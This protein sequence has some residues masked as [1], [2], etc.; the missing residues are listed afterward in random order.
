MTLCIIDGTSIFASA[1]NSI[2]KNNFRALN[3]HDIKPMPRF[4]A[5]TSFGFLA[6]RT[7]AAASHCFRSSSKI[8]FILSQKLCDALSAK[9][10][11]WGIISVNL[12]FHIVDEHWTRECAIS[13]THVVACVCV[14]AAYNYQTPTHTKRERLWRFWN[15]DF[16]FL[17]EWVWIRFRRGLHLRRM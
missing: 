15:F 1:S 12:N 17:R 7:L 8:N 14:L 3:D 11:S 10:S 5:Q 6:P 4:K 9:V 13:V 2:L 16:N